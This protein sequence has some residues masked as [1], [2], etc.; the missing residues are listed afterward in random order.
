MDAQH[1]SFVLGARA[2]YTR[3]FKRYFPELSDKEVDEVVKRLLAEL[4]LR[5][6]R[7]GA[8]SS[9]PGILVTDI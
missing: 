5:S 2:Y 1:E 7:S 9:Q 3:D 6:D 4:S 8:D